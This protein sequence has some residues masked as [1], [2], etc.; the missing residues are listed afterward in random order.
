MH[1]DGGM[2][3]VRKICGARM[4]SVKVFTST[5]LKCVTGCTNMPSPR[6]KVFLT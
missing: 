1:S 4:S 6:S 2:K 5:G 3:P